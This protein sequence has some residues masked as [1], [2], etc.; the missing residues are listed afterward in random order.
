MSFVPHTWK[1]PPLHPQRKRRVRRKIVEKKM[2][3]AEVENSADFLARI[4]TDATK[5]AAEFRK[6]AVNLGYSDMDEGWLIGWFANAIEAGGDRERR[7][8][9]ERLLSKAQSTENT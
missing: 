6:I 4:G 3:E 2:S 7:F 1:L 8:S 9:Q 5:W